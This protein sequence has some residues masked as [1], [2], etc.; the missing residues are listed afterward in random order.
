MRFEEIIICR[1]LH[2]WHAFIALAFKI[3]INPNFSA[4]IP[5]PNQNRLNIDSYKSF[6]KV[7][8]FFCLISKDNKSSNYLAKLIYRTV[9]LFHALN[10][11]RKKGGVLTFDKDSACYEMSSPGMD[12]CPS[13]DAQDIDIEKA[14][15]K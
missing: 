10:N 5:D 7:Y 4:A 2:D 1:L 14:F 3:I 13:K 15:F 8:T 12:A 9:S 6:A 11:Q